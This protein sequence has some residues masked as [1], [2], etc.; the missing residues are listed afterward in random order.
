MKIR[1]E[2]KV[3]FIMLLSIFL[4]VW[5]A[6]FLKGSDLFSKQREFFAIYDRVDGLSVSNP[7][8]I[9]G[10]KVGKVESI[11]FTKD[12]SGKLLV[13]FSIQ[14]EEFNI[15]KDTRARIISSD[16]LGSKS[17]ALQLGTSAELAE[18]LDT[19]GSGIEASLT[20]SV[21][22]QIAPLKKKAEDLIQSVDSAIIIVK[23]VFNETAQDDL[24]H[25]FSSMRSSMAS[26]EKTMSTM[27]LMV[28]EEKDRI[29]GIFKNVESITRNLAQNN[30]N[31][32]KT[33]ANMESISDSLANSTLKQAVNNAS[34]ALNQFAGII[35]K[36][37]NGEG[38]VGQLINND[39]LYTNLEMA[40]YDLDKLMLDLRLNPERYMHFSI[41]GRKDKSKKK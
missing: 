9:N 12:Y 14:N 3:G 30:D 7:V 19:L 23:S 28:Q 27:E 21:N 6:N 2:V 40:A 5:G 41:F 29:Q 35:E 10:F 31:L 36:V 24:G 38:S 34:V 1:K 13:A 15:S 26:F 22:Q 17:L 18:N 39:S 33:M 20:E 25:S 16:I 32:S 11:A 4:L 37:N 8:T